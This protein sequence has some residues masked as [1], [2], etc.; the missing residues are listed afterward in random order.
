MTTANVKVIFAVSTFL[1]SFG[2][3]SAAQDTYTFP[4]VP[5]P[6][7]N[8]LLLEEIAKTVKRDPAEIAYVAVYVKGQSSEVAWIVRSNSSINLVDLA[9]NIKIFSPGDPID[10]DCE[11]PVGSTV[12]K[13][14]AEAEEVTMVTDLGKDIGVAPY[15]TTKICRKCN[16][17]AQGYLSCVVKPTC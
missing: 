5:D 7:P 9:G 14:T 2:G 13:C 11:A 4:S 15:V 3:P 1:L 17:N 12:G 6:D 16:V 8:M 10:L